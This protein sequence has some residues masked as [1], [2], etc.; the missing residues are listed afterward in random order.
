MVFQHF[1]PKSSKKHRF[2]NGFGVGPGSAGLHRARQSHAAGPSRARQ[3]GRGQ[4]SKPNRPGWACQ[5]SETVQPRPAAPIFRG[6]LFMVRV[7]KRAQEAR[8]RGPHD[9]GDPPMCPFRMPRRAQEAQNRPAGPPD[10]SLEV[11]HCAGGRAPSAPTKSFKQAIN[12]HGNTHIHRQAN[13][14]H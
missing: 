2:F 14:N 9:H 3:T 13:T 4:P 10:L 8:Q 12:P 11:C 1:E 7:H 5:P 6:C